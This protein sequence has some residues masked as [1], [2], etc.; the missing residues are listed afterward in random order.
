MRKD[1]N[2][3][4]RGTVNDVK[5]TVCNVMEKL[6]FTV[7]PTLS[8][9]WKVTV[10]SNATTDNSSILIQPAAKYAL[11]VVIGVNPPINVRYVLTDSIRMKEN[12]KNVKIIVTGVRKTYASSARKDFSGRAL[13]VWLIVVKANMV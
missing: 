7:P 5:I 11:K 13:N 9:T 2:L 8:S 12:V 1:S 3:I 6:V 10:L 4:T